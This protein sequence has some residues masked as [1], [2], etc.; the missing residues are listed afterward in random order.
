MYLATTNFLVP[1][2]TFVVE[3]VIFLLLIGVLAKW[4]IPPINRA[5]DVRLEK[6]QNNISDA[7]EAKSKALELEAQYQKTLEQ[8]RI[9]ARALKDEAAKIGEQLRAELRQQ[10][11]EEYRRL[12][13][14]ANQDIVASTRRAAEELRTQV[15]GLVM[16]VVERVLGEGIT[17]SDQDQLVQRA[18]VEIE[19]QGEPGDEAAAGDA[20]RRAR[21]DG[22]DLVRERLRGYADAVLE[23]SPDQ[24]A[25]IA[26]ELQGFSDLLASSTDLHWAWPRRPRPCRPSGR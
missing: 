4:V 6:I 20:F 22:S 15:A 2:A 13:E 5:M 1:N 10:G 14:R 16:D 21:K 26:G 23:T 24:V 19:R 18:I 8:G 9:E 12:L 17:L 11:E 3:L 25:T 7:E